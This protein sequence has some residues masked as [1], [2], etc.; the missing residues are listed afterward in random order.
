LPSHTTRPAFGGTR[1]GEAV[2]QLRLA[3]ALRAGDADGLAAVEGEADGPER[4][5]LQRVD[6]EH[7][8]G[9]SA[10]GAAGGKAASNGRPTMSSTSAA[11][12]VG[13]VE[14][15]LRPARHAGP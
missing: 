5:A 8:A 2:E 10:D 4:L 6:D 1:P 9:S 14:R 7:L 15:A 11:S 12:V 3:V 13:R